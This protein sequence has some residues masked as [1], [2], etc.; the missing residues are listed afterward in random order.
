MSN[1][2]KL[3]VISHSEEDIKNIRNDDIYTPLFVGRNGKD[4]L[5]FC[6]DDS[7]EGNISS[8]NKDYCELTGLYWMWKASDAD[9]IGLC[10]YRRYF[11]G[12]NTKLIEKDE[13][14][15]YLNEYDII[16][17]KKTDLI[18]GS[19]WETY[20][21]HHLYSA[22]KITREVLEEKS[23]KYLETFDKM[24]NQ[25][26]FSNYNMFIAPKDIVNEY[27]SWV[28]PILEE[29]ESKINPDDYP[30]VFGLISE[31]I[32]NVWIEY[33]NLNAKEV[34]I[35]YL[36]GKLRFRMALANNIVLRKGYQFLYFN[37][38]KKSFGKGLEQKIHNLFY[39]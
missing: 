38:F 16:L 10:H 28:F 21:G 11:K 15:K 29:I 4:N 23:P 13:I 9:V 20:E 2:I 25:S 12:K 5:G 3:Y 17:P 33:N 19:Y 31:A 39:N 7:F 1:K 26:S 37:F 32:F 30:R 18:K 36:G 14:T 8:K 35:Y 6:S 22:L 24:L 34:P 27:C